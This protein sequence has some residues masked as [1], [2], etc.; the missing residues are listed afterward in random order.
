MVT[1]VPVIDRSAVVTGFIGRPKELC[2]GEHA[3][4]I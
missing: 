1:P 4:G 3:Q 2:Q